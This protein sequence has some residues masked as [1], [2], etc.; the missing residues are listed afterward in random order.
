MPP[1]QGSDLAVLGSAQGEFLS[2]SNPS[3]QELHLFHAKLHT[4]ISVKDADGVC[5]YYVKNCALKPKKPDV[6]L[7]AGS[8]DTGAI[9]GVCK[10]S[11]LHP[12]KVMVG[13]GDPGI[14]EKDIVW[15]S[16]EPTRYLDQK[17]N[18]WSIAMNNGC[19][20]GFV[21]KRT[22]RVGC[23]GPDTSRYSFRNFK[24]LD[25]ESGEILA[26][27]ASSAVKSWS[28]VGT[29]TFRTD[30]GSEM[31]RMVLLTLLALIEKA[32]RD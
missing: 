1:R 25:G 24:L 26:T 21:W 8:D 15:E 3:T 32:R 17:E 20:R 18:H 22:H 4:N 14:G 16:M 30:L 28:K 27:F 19:R 29:L 31:A 11:N 9:L 6:T 10:W 12:F 23:D 7:Y 5:T 13:L 2:N